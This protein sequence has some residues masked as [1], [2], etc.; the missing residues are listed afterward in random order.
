MIIEC[1]IS[2]TGVCTTPCKVKPKIM[3]G[4]HK[5]LLCEHNKGINSVQGFVNCEVQQCATV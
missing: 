4:S 5:C 3:I 1:E 2:S